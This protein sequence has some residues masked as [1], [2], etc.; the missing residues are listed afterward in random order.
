MPPPSPAKKR[1][2][3]MEAD[4]AFRGGGNP[5]DFPGQHLIIGRP[6]DEDYWQITLDPWQAAVWS[7][8]DHD[9]NSVDLAGPF[10]PL[11]PKE[12][13]DNWS[14]DFSD[15]DSGGDSGDDDADN[16]DYSTFEG[17]N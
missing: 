13:E 11:T 15:N 12:E 8:M 7:A 5:E 16:F 1:W 6:V 17:L 10:E 9:K 4:A 14:F 2:W 3:E